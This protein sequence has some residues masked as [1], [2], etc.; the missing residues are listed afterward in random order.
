MSREQFMNIELTDTLDSRE[1]QLTWLTSSLSK[2][3]DLI[4]IEEKISKD[5]NNP[6][7]RIEKGL[8]LCKSQSFK[9]AIDA[10]SEAIYLNPFHALAYRHR[11]HR[12]LSIRMYREAA[13]D[14]ELSSRIDPSNWDTWYH[15]GLSY[16]LLQEYER[17]ERVYKICYDMTDSDELF[18]AIA[19]WYWMTLVKNNKKKEA[20]D[21]L[22]LVTE[23]MKPGP[24]TSYYRRL[25][26]YKGLLNPDELINFEG[27]LLPDLEL[28]TQGY[29]LGFYYLTQGDEEKAKQMF[30]DV[31]TKS[32]MWSAF[33]YLAS[34]IE[35]DI[36]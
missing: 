22:A 13:A 25:L 32:T 5:P 4:T 26:M 36:V 27:A 33:G 29:G 19:D 20:D 17:A 28:A 30:N 6:E 15:L 9:Q 21:L 35:L 7:L 12:H 31:I 14:F 23:D 11:G 2:S 18:V 34:E 8:E 1:N 10:Y 3:E 16:Y 24:N